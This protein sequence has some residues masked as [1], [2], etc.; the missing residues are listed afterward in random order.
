[1]PNASYHP[2]Y[3]NDEVAELNIIITLAADRIEYDHWSLNDEVAEYVESVPYLAIPRLSARHNL[4][5][6]IYTNGRP[7]HLHQRKQNWDQYW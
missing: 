4:T 1:M 7:H 5:Y 6:N 3:K 2:L